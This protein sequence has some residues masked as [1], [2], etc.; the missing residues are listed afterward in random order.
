M[1]NKVAWLSLVFSSPFFA[2]MSPADQDTI[3]QALTQGTRTLRDYVP[4][5]LYGLN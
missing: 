2:R 5:V 3:V 4:S 1:P